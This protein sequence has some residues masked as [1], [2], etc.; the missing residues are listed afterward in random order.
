MPLA[1]WVYVPQYRREDDFA[2]SWLGQVV[3]LFSS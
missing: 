1:A 2:S 3:R